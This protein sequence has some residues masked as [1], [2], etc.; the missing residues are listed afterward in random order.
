[1]ENHYSWLFYKFSAVSCI[2]SQPKYYKWYNLLKPFCEICRCFSLRKYVFCQLTVNDGNNATTL[3]T[4]I[5]SLF[6]EF[7]IIDQLNY[8]LCIVC[9]LLKL[10]VLK[11][12]YLGE[13][14]VLAYK[15]YNHGAFQYSFNMVKIHYIL[16][17]WLWCG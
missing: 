8:Y 9:Q 16:F 15:L 6:C 14:M 3:N 17:I 11:C 13:S 7:G 1:M 12:F 4:K 2:F 5:C 10:C